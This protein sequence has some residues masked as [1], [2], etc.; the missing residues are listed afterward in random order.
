MAKQSTL[1]E[2]QLS[3]SVKLSSIWLIDMTLSGP[4]NSGLSEPG[5]E[6]KEEVLRIPQSFSVT[7]A[8]PS[9]CL[10]SYP[11]Y[12]VGGLTPLQWCN[13]CILRPQ[14]TRQVGNG[15][16]RMICIRCNIPLKYTETWFS[17]LICINYHKM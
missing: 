8:S 14:S 10:V 13:W 9:D 3:M 11:G 16:M 15:Y 7:G 4:N 6:G 12:S 17:Y 5:S 2:I 1:E